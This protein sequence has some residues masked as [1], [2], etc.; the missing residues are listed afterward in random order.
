MTLHEDAAGERDGGGVGGGVYFVVAVVFFVVGGG[1]S[2]TRRPQDGSV[3]RPLSRPGEGVEGCV[4]GT[5]ALSCLYCRVLMYASC[6]TV[7][8]YVFAMVLCDCKI[9]W[10]KQ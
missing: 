1:G 6:Q 5:A 4:Y 8:I 2:V 9:Y 3:P 7:V 10:S